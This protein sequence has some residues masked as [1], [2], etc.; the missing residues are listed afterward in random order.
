M[1]ADI[2]L[3][4]TRWQA[5]GAAERAQLPALPLGALR[6]PRRAA[7][8]PG[9]AGRSR[10][11]LRLREARA[12][13]PGLVGPHRPVPPRLFRAG[14][15]AGE[16]PG[17]PGGA[18][19]RRSPREGRARVRARKRGTAPAARP[20]WDTAMERARQQAQ[21]YARN[22]P[23]RRAPGGRPAPVP[24][25][26]STWANRSPST[27]SSPARA[28][29]TCTSRTPRPPASPSPTC[30]T[31]PY[32]TC[33]PAV[34]LDP[35]SLDPARRAARV[36]GEIADRLAKL[37]RALEKAGHDP[38]VVA[39][40]LMRCLFTMFAEDVGLLPERSFTQL[41]ADSR[42][43]VAHFPHLVSELWARMASGGYSY[44]L[45]QEIR[46]FNGGLFETPSGAP[47][48]ALALTQDQLQLLIEAAQADWR[49][50]EPA[51]FGTLLE[52][53]LDTVER[54]QLGA[55]FTPRRTWSGWW[56]RPSSSRCGPSGRRCRPRPCAW[57]RAAEAS[58]RPWPKSRRSRSGWPRCGCSTPR[59][60][61]AISSTSAWSTC[62]GWR[63]KCC[64]V[65]Q[66]LG[67]DQMLLELEAVRVTPKQMLGIEI[68]PRAAA[69]AELVLWIGFLRW[70]MQ[71]EGRGA[72]LGGAAPA[73]AAAGQLP[74]HRAAGRGAGVGPGRAA[75]GQG[76]PARDP[77]GR[78]DDEGPPRDGRAGA[79]RDR[80]H[81][82]VAVRQPPARGM[83]GRRILSWG[84]RRL[85]G[86][87]ACAPR[88]ATG[89]PRRS[90][91]PTRTCPSR[92]IM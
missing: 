82:R 86:R 70:R 13:A 1:T 6:R 21:H 57:P 4:I 62:C 2:D 66:E 47:A 15:Q 9:H 91:R 54:H 26:W 44:V 71:A 36:T 22:L 49:D 53:A 55:H 79:R 77:V 67:K 75:A 24:R 27:A 81:P 84:T 72:T 5:S 48:A 17:R 42:R 40:F 16:R 35:M 33:W 56:A 12:A 51:I 80:A 30:G 74:Q 76:R 19:Q 63:P 64:S 60:A 11:R 69:I 46:H 45:R 25:S 61:R 65:R 83:A 32:A 23:Q 85:L 10:E 20:A 90:A 78:P 59:A 31:R 58:T 89:M 43:N 88:W 8:R 34:W 38:D 29:I 18:L 87:A 28:A 7:A 3:F 41:L 73:R 14:G 92:P 50:V 52:H 68:N 39:H 37:A